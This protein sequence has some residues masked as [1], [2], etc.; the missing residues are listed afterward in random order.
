MEL[1]Y[2]EVEFELTKR[3]LSKRTRFRNDKET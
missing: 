2:D 1:S 3:L